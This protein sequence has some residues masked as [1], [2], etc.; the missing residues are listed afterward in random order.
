M[1]EEFLP[2]PIPVIPI[3]EEMR[4]DQ[5]AG[6]YGATLAS[7]ILRGPI[8]L[9]ADGFIRGG[10]TAYNTGTGFF[11]GYSTDAYRFSIGDGS[12]KYLIWDGSTL[13]VSGK[14]VAGAASDIPATYISG[15]LGLANINV[16]ARGWSQDC[17]FSVADANTIAWASG[18]FTSADGTA[19][20]IGAGNTGNMA[21]KTYVYLDIAVSEIAYQTTTTAATSVGAGKCL[22]A[23]AENATGE[24][25]YLVMGGMGGQN[26]DAASIVAN[27]ITANE[28][29]A[30]TITASEVNIA[31]LSA[32]SANLGTVTAG[33]LSTN[34]LIVGTDV[35]T[36]EAR[37]NALFK[38]FV[39]VGSQNDG[40]TESAGG[41]I[42]RGPMETSLKSDGGGDPD[43]CSLLSDFLAG[44]MLDGWDVDYEFVVV[45]ELSY[46]TEQ[47]AFWG[48][49]PFAA[50]PADATATDEHMGFYV[51]DGTLYASNGSGSAQTKTQITGITITD[52]NAYRFIFDNGT[53]IKFYVNEVLKAT[54]TTNLP[55]GAGGPKLWFGIECQEAPTSY[56]T[57]YI[58]NNYL[59]TVL[60]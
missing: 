4:L 7:P 50:V 15:V 33:T 17:A 40:L 39:F 42:A 29:A 10:Q 36:S 12:S 60:T 53:N 23:V 52:V 45:T 44:T 13:T 37:F 32:I 31:T 18:T 49:A 25:T 56:R 26:I 57:L 55:S 16:A 47:D 9:P 6:Y 22:V 24:A 43:T 46:N 59:V 41:T 3:E 54:H 5:T 14:L 34:V 8:T 2:D 21:A 48:F 30:N 58:N 11:L 1:E 38:D 20:S 27:S 35:V 28:I 19:Y 51:Q